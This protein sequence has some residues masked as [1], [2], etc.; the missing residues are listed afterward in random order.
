MFKSTTNLLR[1]K[2]VVTI[3]LRRIHMNKYIFSVFILFSA[4]TIF[5]Q[6]EKAILMYTES[7]PGLTSQLQSDEMNI[8]ITPEMLE[9]ESK[10]KYSYESLV[11]MQQQLAV[12]GVEKIQGYL[13]PVAVE[14]LEILNKLSDL[15][16]EDISV[17]INK[18][19]NFFEKLVRTFQFWHLPSKM[20]NKLMLAINKE[21]YKNHYQFMKSDTHTTH[22]NLAVSAG[23]G[24]PSRL[25][26]YLKKSVYFNNIPDQVGFYFMF[27]SG[28][29]FSQSTV[30]TSEGQKM[31]L[32][33][34]PV[35]EYKRGDRFFSPFGYVSASMNVNQLWDNSENDRMFEKTRFF[36]FSSVGTVRSDKMFGITTGGGIVFPPGL[37]TVAGIEGDG[38]IIKLKKQY[39]KEFFGQLFVRNKTKMCS[40]YF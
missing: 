26:Q 19:N 4:S 23:I 10:I 40:S 13:I 24:F 30:K 34:S 11:Y 27:S 16:N 32:S 2:E 38:M 39:F 31:Q 5:S 25:I 22:V 35:I 36:K 21:F 28:I 6:T 1:L 9:G 7:I 12:S 14:N 15:S 17:F 3:L 8:K 29:A 37:S 18:K 33:I 20:A